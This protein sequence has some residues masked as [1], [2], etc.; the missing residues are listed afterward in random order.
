GEAPAARG[1]RGAAEAP[2]PPVPADAYHPRAA[3]RGRTV[4]PPRRGGGSAL[5]A[6]VVVGAEHRPGPELRQVDEL[7]GLADERDADAVD[8]VPRAVHRPAGQVERR[9]ARA[10]R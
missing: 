1:V 2:A 5:D 3:S 4:R 8:D 9:G 6:R 7:A 10:Q